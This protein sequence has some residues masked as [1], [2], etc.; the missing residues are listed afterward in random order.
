M[1]A[2]I[3]FVHGLI[4]GTTLPTNHA[5]WVAAH[6][7]PTGTEWLA[8]Y[9]DEMLAQFQTWNASQALPPVRPWDGSS[10]APWDST[11]GTAAPAN[12]SPPFTGLA[13]L[14]ALG[15]ALRDRLNSVAISLELSGKTKAP[16][17]YRFWS[18]LKWASDRRE[19]FLGNPVFPTS[20]VYDRDGTVLSAKEFTDTFNDLHRNW[21]GSLNAGTVLTPE[22]DSTVGQRVDSVGGAIPGITR[23]Q[24]F[25]RFHRDHVQLFHDWLARTG[26]D[27]TV[28]TDMGMPGGWPT[29]MVGYVPPAPW[30]STEATAA[31]SAPFLA[32][33][34][35]DDVGAIEFG[36]HGTGHVQN[37]DI[38]PLPYN[39]YVTRFHM[40]HGWIDAQLW[41]RAPRFAW[42]DA[43]TSERDRRFRPI[44]QDG[45]DFPDRTAISIVRDPLS[46][47]DVIH[48]PNALAAYDLTTGDG[49]LRLKLYVRDT[50]GRT[51]RMRLT[52]DIL[53]AAG[54][55]VAGLSSV[56]L[57]TI[58]TGGDHPLDTDFEED[59]ALTGAFVS[60]DPLRSNAAVGFVYAR[61]RI[62]GELWV[63]D[64]LT[65]DDPAAS[66]DPGF[67]HRDV[68]TLELVREKLGPTAT[69]SLELSSFSQGHVDAL[70]VEGE[71]RFE[72]AF[73]VVL[74]DRTEAS[75]A[76]PV[77]PTF[78]ADEVKGLLLGMPAASGLFDDLAHA[79]TLE[80]VDSV[81]NAPVVGVHA[82]F[83]SPPSKEDP[84]L[85]PS[86]TQRHTW[87]GSIV[88][89]AGHDAFA[90]LASGDRRQ[91]TLR[92]HVRDRAGNS[93]Q[94][95]VPLTL[96]VDANPFMTDGAKSW[97][98]IDTRVL[99]VEAGE[100][101]LGSVLSAGAP[102][103]WL[104]TVLA[105]LNAGT[106]GAE[107]FDTLATEG[108][109]AALEYAEQ[110]ENFDT[111]AVTPVYNF[112]F[113]KVRLRGTTGAAAV[114]AFFR[115]F[116][117][118][119]PNLL[120]DDTRGYRAFSDGAG[121]V[122]AV[123][124]YE[125]TS[126]GDELLS[127]PFFAAARLDPTTND[128]SSQTDPLN[129]KD[130]PAGITTEQVLYFGAWLDF[131][132]P[133]VRLPATYDAALPYGPYPAGTQSLTTLMRDFHQCMVVE[134]R[135]DPDPTEPGAAPS[136]S[137][138]LAQ[139][140]LVI[141][142]SANPGNALTRTVEHSFLIDLMA[143]PQF[144][145]E[146]NAAR[147][148]NELH[149]ERLRSG[150][151]VD[152]PPTPELPLLPGDSVQF[153]DAGRFEKLRAEEAMN[154][155][156][157]TPFGQELMASH[158][159]HAHTPNANAPDPAGHADH[160]NPAPGHTDPTNAQTRGVVAAFHSHADVVVRRRAPFV[161][162]RTQ[163]T[164]TLRAVDELMLRWGDFPSG[165][166]AR[167]ILSGVS[168]EDV[169][170]LRA[171]RHAP[172]TVWSE[173]DG[174]LRLTPG[175]VTYLP[176]P[177]NPRG[178]VA[179]LLRV[180]L[181]Q[182]VKAGQRH[183]VDII[184]LQGG[185]AA[186]KGG[187]RFAVEVEHAPRF[188][189]NVTAGLLR[190]H[191]QLA[192]T[193]ETSVWHPILTRRLA[194]ERRRARALHDYVGRPWVDPTQWTD[195]HG[196]THPVLG[197][198]LRVVLEAITI[199]DD[200]D[201][202]LKCNGEFE[203]RARVGSS[204]NG[205][206]DQRTRIPRH[207][208]LKIGTGETRQLNQVIFEGFVS[209]TL[210]VRLDV[211]EKDTLDPDDYLGR[212]VRTFRGKPSTFFGTYGPDGSWA[213]EEDLGSWAIRYRIERG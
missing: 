73:Y 174:V 26:Q 53:D 88:F 196:N 203:L 189:T 149:L 116:R 99:A 169:E 180:T 19:L 66:L 136:T 131:N 145:K 122:I 190:L 192:L 207:G 96:F 129:V 12:L 46:A 176:I 70:A 50:F 61:V 165:T 187:V 86:V 168:A 3:D 37:T 138:N 55:V 13:S 199:R 82:E 63:P 155:G 100:E 108:P 142:N 58:G 211:T 7:A 56:V 163:W 188:I 25:I 81:T 65:P 67:V 87:V 143:P 209:S 43:A 117:Y 146:R 60:D 105:A 112:A 39:N 27:P 10:P 118:S 49:T 20:V 85:D 47:T 130:F 24:D 162:D 23:A 36:Y 191:E 28:P 137:D 198:K 74:Q 182:G 15:A 106:T 89:E 181:P 59:L 183:F 144:I 107:T 113:A 204:D 5:D 90:G 54:N 29:T 186:V 158:R 45:S 17:S 11:V 21:H 213:C 179:A 205:G 31:T 33:A 71:S 195:A 128:L 156:M 91:L 166:E 115:L 134:L 95:E 212:Y 200:S 127:I 126:S 64:P 151:L 170:N 201:P 184:Q 41:W 171:L 51:L 72:S 93:T 80:L 30:A 152:H 164:E 208:V 157:F 109:G 9:L 135:Y 150:T 133:S 148:H 68:T 111:G 16:F 83:T 141:G 167:L 94:T 110:R 18:F 194:L 2:Y 52:V 160:A 101:R 161:F 75:V 175:G 35:L 123:P 210:A 121:R 62:T 32:L 38:S 97:L 42:S 120:F 98:S 139:R 119:A 140:N 77:W 154:L 8:H 197:P 177:P 125:G 102:R 69:I 132:Q 172:R 173:G 193:N 114:R 84:G 159:H 185:S 57:R 40:W 34:T 124:G 44:L 22:H 1:N 4:Y 6:A 76:P 79:P 153:V 48:P 147:E 104:N 92:V 202:F 14:D 206:V 178:Q 78:T 103:D